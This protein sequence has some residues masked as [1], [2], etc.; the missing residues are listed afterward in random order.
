M[1]SSVSGFGSR[2]RLDG[3]VLGVATLTVKGLSDVD[4]LVALEAAGHPE[5]YQGWRDWTTKNLEVRGPSVL[6]AAVD[7]EA[8]TWTTPLRFA[9]RPGAL[10]VRVSV[11]QPGASPAFL[12][13]PVTVSTLLGLARVVRGVPSGIV[14]KR[15]NT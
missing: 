14:G 10:R 7:G 9:V 6:A 15:G 2:S 13:A 8:R 11:D 5:R 12:H 3:G 1:L 4:R